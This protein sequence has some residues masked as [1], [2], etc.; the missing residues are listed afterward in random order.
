MK[1]PDYARR[2]NLLGIQYSKDPGCSRPRFFLYG[3]VSLLDS[4]V[5]VL[6][7]GFF[8]ATWRETMLFSDFCDRK[9]NRHE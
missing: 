1:A 6:S 7:L 2:K 5:I 4:T 8:T 9:E 3:L